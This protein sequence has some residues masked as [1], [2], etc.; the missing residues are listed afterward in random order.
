MK[1]LD[2]NFENT[3]SVTRDMHKTWVGGNVKFSFLLKSY[4]QTRGKT[5]IQNS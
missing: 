3:R 5:T 2:T 1:H 4:A